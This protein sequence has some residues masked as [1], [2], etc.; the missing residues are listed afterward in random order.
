MSSFL[1]FRL[2]LRVLP[3]TAT[4]LTT[5][6][7]PHQHLHSHRRL[8]SSNR[9][10]HI[11]LAVYKPLEVCPDFWRTDR[12]YQ[13]PRATE[14]VNIALNDTLA[15]RQ[16]VGIFPADGYDLG[17]EF[18]GL[19]LLTSDVSIC[20]QAFNHR[21]FLDSTYLVQV[22]GVPTDDT[23]EQLKKG[24][25]V[26]IRGRR[27]FKTLPL[28]SSPQRISGFPPWVASHFARVTRDGMPISTS[29]ISLTVRMHKSRM[30]CK[31]LD[32]VGLRMIRCVKWASSGFS[33]KGMLPGEVK[34]FTREEFYQKLGIVPFEKM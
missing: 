28:P 2:P 32:K 15:P 12:L 10:R 4:T 31:M 34:E 33:L 16:S 18:E 8:L 6:L 1:L 3:T 5:R 20:D 30:V 29:W 13:M 19:V 27:S 23:L 21:R 17:V 22:E 24:V 25:K 7:R 9:Q 14:K 26:Y 11:Y